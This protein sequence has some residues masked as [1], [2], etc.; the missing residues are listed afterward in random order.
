MNGILR[1]T[2]EQEIERLATLSHERPVLI[3]KHSTACPTSSRSYRLYR[4]YVDSAPPDADIL[5]AEV[6][7][8]ENRS[9][10]NG[11]AER[12]GVRHQTPQALLISNGESAWHASHWEITEEAM[13]EAR[14]QAT[15]G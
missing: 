5:F 10:S 13:D 14:A 1:L 8:I 12:F 6:Y 15:T 7:V 4:D 2:S 11:I 3:F 9:V